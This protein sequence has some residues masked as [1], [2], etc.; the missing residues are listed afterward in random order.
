M[1]TN[2]LRI[3]LGRRREQTEQ[4]IRR[5]VVELRRSLDRIE[6]NLDKDYHL[7]ALGEIQGAGSEIDRLV[8]LRQELVE[9]SNRL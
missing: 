4:S 6:T 9:I 1:D 3:E 7:N 8:A 5:K 2:G